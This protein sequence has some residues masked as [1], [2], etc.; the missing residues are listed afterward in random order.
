MLSVIFQMTF[1]EPLK[2]FRRTLH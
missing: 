2:W 1:V